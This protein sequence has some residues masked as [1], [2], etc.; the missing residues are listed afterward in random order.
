MPLYRPANLSENSPVARV[1]T[2]ATFAGDFRSAD[3]GG[4][5]FTVTLRSDG[6]FLTRRTCLVTANGKDESIYDLG[7]WS[8][9]A[10]GTR[11]VLRGGKEALE[12]FAVKDANTIHQLDNEGREIVSQQNYDLKRSAEI[13]PIGDTFRMK[14]E[15]VFLADAG[16]FTQCLT[17]ASFPIAQE[18]D[19]SALE[20]AYASS[21]VAGGTPLL[22]TLEGRLAKRVTES[23]AEKETIVVERFDRVWRK[24]RCPSRSTGAQ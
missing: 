18:K 1:A 3:C 19:I 8:L 16:V 10:S 6:M 2:P 21:G 11:L 14:G 22:V 12:Q 17:E 24:Q 13:D 5:R 9:E 7:R 23:G 20:R 15:F 4:T